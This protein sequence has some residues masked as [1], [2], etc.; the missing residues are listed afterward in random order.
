[1]RICIRRGAKQIGGTCIE[2]ESQGQRLVL[3]I[4][5]PL[6][7]SD[8]ESADMPTVPGFDKSDPFLL[9]VVLSHPHMDHYGL[10]FRAPTSTTF[11]MGEAAERILAAAAVF[12]P[13]GGTF[14]HVIHLVNRKPIELGPFR[15]TPYLMDHSAYDSYAKA[16][17][18]VPTEAEWGFKGSADGDSL[19]TVKLTTA[20]LAHNMQEDIASSPIF[21]LCLAYWHQKATGCYTRCC[22]TVS[23]EAPTSGLPLLHWRRSLFILHEL[24]AILGER[25]VCVLPE[26][27]EKWTWPQR[28]EMN[29]EKPDRETRASSGGGK[30]YDLE[31]TIMNSPS[32]LES[33]K[34]IRP[35]F[36]KFYRQFPIG[37]FKGP[38]CKDSHWTP[39]GNS[40]VDLWGHTRDKQ[41]LHL[42]EL[43]THE[44]KKVGII[45]EALYYARR[46]LRACAVL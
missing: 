35:G 33:M 39:G 27:C 29:N 7:C 38:P 24:H 41:I 25:F 19:I 36:E 14:D 40:Q 1:M 13:S 37:L 5:Q 23:G 10:A 20:Q 11:L 34:K 44:N 2:I 18:C 21:A 9:G 12:T 16:F 3:D 45:S 17:V 31:L 22:I 32:F 8:A 4:G 6:D 42:F 43:K 15:I 46:A 30:E 26:K 28:P